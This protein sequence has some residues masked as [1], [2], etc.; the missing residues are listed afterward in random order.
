MCNTNCCSTVRLIL[1]RLFFS[2]IRTENHRAYQVVRL[3]KQM[4]S[5]RNQSFVYLGFLSDEMMKH[6]LWRGGGVHFPFL[7]FEILWNL[8]W[9][10]CLNYAQNISTDNFGRACLTHLA[11]YDLPE[12]MCQTCEVCWSYWKSG[13][14]TVN[15]RK[16]FWVHLTYKM[17]DERCEVLY[18]K[19]GTVVLKERYRK[20]N[21]ERELN[22]HIRNQ[23]QSNLKVSLPEYI[24]IRGRNQRWTKSTTSWC[25]ELLGTRCRSLISHNNS[26]SYSSAMTIYFDLVNRY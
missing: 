8:T 24:I 25:P 3:P 26:S 19:S 4:N 14:C 15:L 5:K 10:S 18:E 2:I 7:A 20:C 11:H 12:S 21:E 16:E 17:S 13:L 1:T 23:V 6:N 9:H 22:P